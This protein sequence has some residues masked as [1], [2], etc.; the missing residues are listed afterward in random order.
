MIFIPHSKLFP[1]SKECSGS[2]HNCW[3]ATKLKDFCNRKEKKHG[4]F[5]YS[6]VEYCTWSFM[7]PLVVSQAWIANCSLVT[8]LELL[9]TCY[10]THMLKACRLHG[11]VI[12]PSSLIPLRTAQ[13]ASSRTWQPMMV[14]HQ[15][16]RA[17]SWA[18]HFPDSMVLRQDFQ[19]HQIP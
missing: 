13:K 18:R 4:W 9:I 16:C 7:A 6:R 1:K 14:I 5:Q 8:S 17:T 2:K 10:W 15:S 11:W 3:S 19:T 12:R